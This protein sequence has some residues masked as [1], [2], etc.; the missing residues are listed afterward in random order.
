[1]IAL[2][3]LVSASV[4]PAWSREGQASN[5]L[6]WGKQPDEQK[7]QQLKKVGVKSLICLRTNSIPKTR[8]FAEGLGMKFFHVKTGVMLKPTRVEME[9]FMSIVSKPENQPVYI[10][11]VGGR[12]RTAFYIGLYRMAFEGWNIDQARKELRAHRLRRKWP[13]FW[14]YDNA[15]EDNS[16]WIRQ[17]MASHHNK[18]IPT[19]PTIG[20]APC[21]CHDI[22]FVDTTAGAPKVSATKR[23]QTIH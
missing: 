15:L 21:P 20:E 8:Q 14:L 1:L 7:I 19:Q 2:L 5:I 4:L 18:K 11:C 16:A 13:I 23:E 9:K 17:Y 6:Y 22:K 12:D 3:V 10:F